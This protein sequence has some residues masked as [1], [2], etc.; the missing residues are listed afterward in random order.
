M[1]FTSN[2][3][4]EK[5]EK[6]NKDQESGKIW[7]EIKELPIDLFSLANQKISDYAELQFVEPSKCYL[8]IKVGSVLPAL[9][10]SIGKKYIVSMDALYTI[11]SR[12]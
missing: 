4:K 12:A 2:L 3:S 5:I 6:L 7:D 10:T 11:V 1:T 8:K 9:E